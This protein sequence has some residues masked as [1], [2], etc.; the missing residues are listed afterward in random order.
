MLANR[1]DLGHNRRVNL[2]SSLVHRGEIVEPTRAPAGR[3]ALV[4]G[5]RVLPDGRPTR[6]LTD[7]IATA[8]RLF[9]DHLT[10]RLLLTGLPREVDAMRRELLL[11][12]VPELALDED[13]GA[14]TT[15]ASFRRARARFGAIPVAVITQRFHLPRALFLAH[16]SGLDAIGVA[17]D[18]QAYG[19]S[20]PWHVLREGAAW[21]KALITV[22]VDRP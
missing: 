14:A 18:L 1:F 4:L 5:A 11:R 16:A 22:A 21:M 12:G 9:H 17:A 7:R 10:P 13:R 2:L 8:A 6:M 19:A 15:A 20:G 3:P